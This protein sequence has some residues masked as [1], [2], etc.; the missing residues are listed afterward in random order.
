MSQT[1]RIFVSELYRSKCLNW[2]EYRGTE[3]NL[4]KKNILACPF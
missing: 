4:F 2:G 1:D 3:Y